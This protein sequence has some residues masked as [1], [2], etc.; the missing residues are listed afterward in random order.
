MAI[1]KI[2]NYKSLIILIVY[3][4]ATYF[5]NIEIWLFLLFPPSFLVIK[6][7]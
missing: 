6:S 2:L 3:F 7:F 4:F 1:N 5:D